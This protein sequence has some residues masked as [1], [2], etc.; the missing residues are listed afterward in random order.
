M[1]QIPREALKSERKE[2][3]K[4]QVPQYYTERRGTWDQQVLKEGYACENGWCYQ[5]DRS[6]INDGFEEGDLATLFDESC[7]V[8]QIPVK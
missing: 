2:L 3:V 7:C 4:H 8:D 1:T 5:A 6:E